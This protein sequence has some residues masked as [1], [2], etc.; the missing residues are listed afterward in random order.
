MYFASADPAKKGL[1]KLLSDHLAKKHGGT[2]YERPSK[3][4]NN[5]AAGD[6]VD[7]GIKFT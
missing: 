3:K 4:Y 5:P 2:V 6:S 1:H 7:H